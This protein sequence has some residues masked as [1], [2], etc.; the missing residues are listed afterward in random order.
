MLL[1]PQDV[2]LVTTFPNLAKMAGKWGQNGGVFVVGE[3]LTAA[4]WCA[5]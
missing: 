5:K 1:M 2:I 3:P 4:G